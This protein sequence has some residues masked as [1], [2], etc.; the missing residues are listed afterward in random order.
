[1]E[2]G[3]RT[4]QLAARSIGDCFRHRLGSCLKLSPPKLQ[5]VYFGTNPK[6]TVVC[7][8]SSN[9]A[10]TLKVNT[11]L[12]SVF[13]GTKP[14]RTMVCEKSLQELDNPRHRPS[15]DAAFGRVLK[16]T[17]PRHHVSKYAAFGIVFQRTA[18]QSV[19]LW[20]ET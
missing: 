16:R 3:K 12:Q 5:S 1:M 20:Y 7:N 18:L 17:T 19:F 11:A 8:Q 15:R 13:L 4:V 6:R 2:R 10:K 14:K 9:Y